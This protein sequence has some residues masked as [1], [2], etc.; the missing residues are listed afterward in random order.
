MACLRL[1]LDDVVVAS[2]IGVIFIALAFAEGLRSPRLA[3]VE[4]VVLAEPMSLAAA[5][6]AAAR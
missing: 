4:P 5:P 2:V 1:A 6:L 3:P